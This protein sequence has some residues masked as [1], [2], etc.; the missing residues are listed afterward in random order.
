MKANYNKHGGTGTSE[1]NTWK[2]IKQRINNPNNSDYHDYGGRGIQICDSWKD[3]FQTFILDMGKK[4]SINH[5]IERR[6]NNGNYEPSNCYWATPTEQANNK[7]SSLKHIY[8]D[9]ELTVSQISKEEE[10][11]YEALRRRL[12]KGQNLDIAIKALKK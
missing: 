8:N 2:M 4:P 3:S 12:N 11:S 7:S 5:S 9:K 6:D 10:I 1:Y